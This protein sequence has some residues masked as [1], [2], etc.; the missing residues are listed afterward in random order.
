MFFVK[1]YQL[2]NSFEIGKERKSEA[3]VTNLTKSYVSFI[4]SE[5]FDK[6]NFGWLR[7]LL[8]YYMALGS[9]STEWNDERVSSS[10][11]SGQLN[12]CE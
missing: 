4:G 8:P 6:E 3:R 2:V 10:I 12:P 11:A 7:S 9:I 1:K 5:L